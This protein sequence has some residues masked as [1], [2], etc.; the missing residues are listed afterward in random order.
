M[1]NDKEINEIIY[2]INN[3]REYDN[4]ISRCKKIEMTFRKF[5]WENKNGK[6]WF[7]MFGDYDFTYK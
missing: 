4:N 2:N 6:R 5:D 1:I 3:N 7:Y